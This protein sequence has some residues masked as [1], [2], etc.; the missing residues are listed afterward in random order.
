MVE[1]A[2]KFK[3]LYLLSFVKNLIL[4]CIFSVG[5]GTPIDK[6]VSYFMDL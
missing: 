1:S 5:I 3:I 6:N 4:H 2:L